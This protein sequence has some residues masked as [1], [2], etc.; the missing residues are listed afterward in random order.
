MQG[1]YWMKWILSGKDL[2]NIIHVN[3]SDICESY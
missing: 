3:D 2:S 1:I